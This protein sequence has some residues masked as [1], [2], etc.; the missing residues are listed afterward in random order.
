MK[1]KVYIR[2]SNGVEIHLTLAETTNNAILTADGAIRSDPLLLVAKEKLRDA[3]ESLERRN[4]SGMYFG[5]KDRN[6]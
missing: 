4:A 1:R 6:T 5:I 3:L 2:M